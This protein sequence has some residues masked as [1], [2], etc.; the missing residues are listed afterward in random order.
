MFA[1]IWSESLVTCLGCLK[2][3]LTAP[4]LGLRDLLIGVEDL[5]CGLGDLVFAGDWSRSLVLLV[6]DLKA[7]RLALS[8]AS[9][10]V[11]M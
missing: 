10:D 6:F 9:Y 11:G 8:N 1:G 5:V 7:W 3:C 2:F 4:G